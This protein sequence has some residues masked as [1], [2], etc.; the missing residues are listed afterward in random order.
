M[1]PD[2]EG[3]ARTGKEGGRLEEEEQLELATVEGYKRPLI[4]CLRVEAPLPWVLVI[5]SNTRN[6]ANQP[7]WGSSESQVN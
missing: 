7:L 1:L 6:M 4:P 3:L 2:G 5:K